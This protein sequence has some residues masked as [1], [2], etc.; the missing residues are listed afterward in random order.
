[1]A[2]TSVL[3]T[4]HLRDTAGDPL[5]IGGSARTG[6]QK[7]RKLFRKLD[8]LQKGHERPATLK[9]GSLAAWQTAVAASSGDTTLTINGVDIVVS[10]DT[11]QTITATAVAA[12][13]NAS[14]DAL[15]AGHVTASNLSTT[16]ALATC[17][18]QGT[19]TICGY[20]LRPVPKESLGP[21]TFEV[22]GNNSADGDKLVAA[23][24]AMPGL[25]DLVV[26]INSAGTVTV[27]SRVAAASLPINQLRASGTSGV[28]LGAG[29]MAVGTTVLIS[30]VNKGIAGNTITA[31][32]TGTGTSIGAARLAGGTSASVTLP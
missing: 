7:V 9:Y 23:I 17:L 11:S 14:A 27:R 21:G 29:A 32:I 10:F 30:A 13:V 28:T 8:K 12:A 20:P 18:P 19:I 24:H 1:M 2:T 16:I 15:V 31:A 3:L 26:A 5:L 4:Y 22:S 6:R 25:Q